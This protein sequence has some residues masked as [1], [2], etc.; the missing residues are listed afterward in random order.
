MDMI[1]VV[2]TLRPAAEDAQAPFWWGRAAQKLFLSAVAGVD[3][4]LA[5]T[6]HAEQ[7][8]HPYSVSTLMGRFPDGRLDPALDYTLRLTAVEPGLAAL[9]ETLTRPGGTLGQGAAIELD[10]RAFTVAAA[11]ATDH[12]WAG[13]AG[14]AALTAA[15]LDR[16]A[17][18]PRRISL[19]WA[20]PVTFRSGGKDVPLPIPELVFGSLLER[21]NASAPVA[22]PPETRRYAVECLAVSR[23]DLTTRSVAAKEGAQRIGASGRV[24]FTTF[25]Y[26]R[27]WMGVLHVLAAFSRF[28]GLGAGVSYGLGQ[29]RAVGESD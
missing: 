2:L 24:S 29:C 17:P 16:T 19:H 18:P 20:S 9:L 15:A 25:R 22:F 5:D 23:Y 11:T 26:D 13:R 21:W 3:P 14:Y 7:Q 4:A 10:R 28:A 27:Y 1:A 6:L 12:P 8:P